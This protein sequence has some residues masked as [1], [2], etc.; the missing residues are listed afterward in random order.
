M[1]SPIF[2]MRG[3]PQQVQVDGASMT[4]RSRGRCSG[5]GLRAGRRRSKAETFVI[6]VATRSAAISSS[7]ASASSS[8]SCNFICSISRARRSELWPYCSRRILAISSLRCRIIASDVVTTAR[9]CARSA[10]AEAARAS[11]AAS[12]ARSLAI[13]EAASSMAESYHAAC[14]KP[15]KNRGMQAASLPSKAAASSAGCA[16]RSLPGDSRAAPTIQARRSHSG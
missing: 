9:T 2:T 1:S 3:E 15:N 7:V 13:S 6:L 8:W 16:S 5:N 14:R 11:D 10:S 4:R 12:A